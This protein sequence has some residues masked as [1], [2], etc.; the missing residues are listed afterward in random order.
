M[1]RSNHFEAPTAEHRL[2]A[3]AGLEAPRQPERFQ[4]PELEPHVRTVMESALAD[5]LDLV[6]STDSTRITAHQGKML[7][8]LTQFSETDLRKLG[9]EYVG[10]H[11]IFRSPGSG[12]VYSADEVDDFLNVAAVAQ[13]L[14]GV[15]GLKL[16]DYESAR[17]LERWHEVRLSRSIDSD[18]L[19]G[20]PSRWYTRA[21]DYLRQIDQILANQDQTLLTP[22]TRKAVEQQREWAIKQKQLENARR[23]NGEDQ[24]QRTAQTILDKIEKRMP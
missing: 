3:F 5:N 16:E 9:A 2:I 4:E 14:R 22:T 1:L 11:A 10:K 19:T 7:K 12:R 13:R 15:P 20:D 17:R 18:E 24:D 6:H 23:K 21:D 8:R